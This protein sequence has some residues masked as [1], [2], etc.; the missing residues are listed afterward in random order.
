MEQ[1]FPR[2]ERFPAD[3]RTA[4]TRRVMLGAFFGAVAV[5]AATTVLT[6]DTMQARKAARAEAAAREIARA[7]AFAAPPGSC[8]TW[9]EPEAADIRKVDCTEPH[10]FELVGTADLEPILGKNT[11][12]PSA[13]RWQELKE[14]H[15]TTL[16]TDYMNGKLDPFGRF[17]VGALTPSQQ[18]WQNGDKRLRCGLQIVGPSG[19]VFSVV[20]SATKL[21]Q[22]DVHEVGTCIGIDGKSVGDPG[23]DCAGPHA[24]E[25]VGVIDLG[26]LFH[27]EEY[28]DTKKQD[29]PLFESCNAL[30]KEYSGGKDISTMGLVVTWDNLAQESWD[31]GSR[32]VNCKVGAS[33]PDGSGLAP[34]TGSIKGEVQV[35][36]EPA[37][38]A[39]KVRPGSPATTVPPPIPATPEEEQEEGQGE[40]S[41]DDQQNSEQNPPGS[42]ENQPSQEPSTSPSEG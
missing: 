24:Y 34:V 10:L 16:A 32:K 23:V 11:P 21:D 31:A 22:S 3:A 9:T 8:L 33:L 5:L 38:P 17:S 12:Y 15:C 30:A 14:E 4:G 37:P 42:E 25:I 35:G 6:W 39:E 1:M 28:P 27:D 29:P 40:E 7:E 2:R 26:V 19:A 13:E 18:G 20:G 41:P 36:T